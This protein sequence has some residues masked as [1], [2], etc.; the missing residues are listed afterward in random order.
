M[1]RCN[2]S[3]CVATKVLRLLR[4]SKFFRLLHEKLGDYAQSVR[5]FELFFIFVTTAHW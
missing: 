5:L 4:L 3:C 2:M 1:L